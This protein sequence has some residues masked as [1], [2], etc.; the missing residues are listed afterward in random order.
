MF[1]G[2][3]FIKDEPQLSHIE[4][5]RR[6]IKEKVL[7]KDRE[8]L[9]KAVM[10]DR[11]AYK[12][13]V[14]DNDYTIHSLTDNLKVPYLN[15]LFAFMDEIDK[16]YS[17]WDIEVAIFDHEGRNKFVFSFML[18]FPEVI[19]SNNYDTH[20]IRE[21]F[22][23]FELY[24]CGISSDRQNLIFRPAIPY[25]V[26]AWFE[27][28]EWNSGYVHSHLQS[29]NNG[30]PGTALEFKMFCIGNDHIEEIISMLGTKYDPYLF[31]SYLMVLKT[32]A[33]WESEDGVPY[34][35]IENITGR[36]SDNDD[37]P[38][39]AV[40]DDYIIEKAMRVAD[41][42]PAILAPT[43]D[44]RLADNKYRAVVTKKTCDTLIE[45]IDNTR[46]PYAM[47]IIVKRLGNTYVRYTAPRA[48][49]DPDT[50][51]EYYLIHNGQRIHFTLN[52]EDEEEQNEDISTYTLNPKF[53]KIL[54]NEYTAILQ[55][56]QFIGNIL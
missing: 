8:W 14:Q 20:E 3:S 11:V 53:I 16:Q 44:F 41:N 26:R 35:E 2:T 4:A 12:K 51:S 42:M 25:G 22:I 7:T 32:V 45:Y 21:L 38:Q 18:R 37:G 47:N 55:K 17:D 29:F 36:Q 52:V 43:F 39:V 28:D 30:S 40:F 54:E 13:H 5:Y 10:N 31:A 19:I 48:T 15:S 33:E 50:N 34:M 56:E 1:R 49:F 6:K 27:E 9:E 24:V 23:A 46:D